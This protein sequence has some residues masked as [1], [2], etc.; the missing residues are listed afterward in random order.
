MP[1]VKKFRLYKPTVETSFHIDFNWWREN[2][3]NWLIYLK[4]FLCEEHRAYFEDKKDDI[5]IDVVDPET[6]EVTQMDGL[7]YALMHHCAKQEGFISENVPL[8]GKIFRTFLANGNEP[9]TPKELETIIK[10]PARTIL[11]TL[12]GPQ[13]YKGIRQ[14]R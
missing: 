7:L 1:E 11:I 4:D 9:L 5:Q 10:K 14:V 13:V 12:T 3:S 2:D 8:V 6:A